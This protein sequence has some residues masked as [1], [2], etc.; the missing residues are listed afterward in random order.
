LARPDHPGQDDP[1][2]ASAKR[3]A[4]NAPAEAGVDV[5]EATLTTTVTGDAIAVA[6][7]GDSIDVATWTLISRITGVVKIAAIGAVLGPT[8]FGNTYQF[9]NSL[10]NLIYFGFLAGSLFSSLL[11]PALVRHVGAND[12]AASERIAG[13][14]LGTTLLTL[15]VAAPLAVVCGPM[16]LR[17]AS[18]G[19]AHGVG[20]AQE[21]V[22]RLLIVMFLPQLF[23]Y[24]V[25]GTATAAMNAHR[26]FALAAAAPALENVGI[27]VV[28]GVAAVSY[29]HGAR[30]EHVPVGLLVLLGLG[31]TGAVLL[32]AATQWWGA[33]R[34]GVTLVPR[35][36]WRD[37]EVTAVV[38]RALPSLAQAGL[39]A[40]QVGTLLALANRV[41]GGVTA[42][43]IALNCYFLAIALGATPVALSLLPRLAAMH[44]AQDVRSFSDTFA[45]GLSLGIFLA[46]PAAVGY[47]VLAWPL[48]HALSFGRMGSPAGVAMV[49]GALIALAA[50]VVAQTVF[51]I[52]TYASYA[53][54]DTTA[55]LRAMCGQAIACL[56]LASLA[57]LVHGAAVLTVLGMAFTISVAL[58]AMH[59]TRQ[60]RRGRA[61][62]SACLSRSVA[63]AALA[64]AVMA[65]PV[66][67]VA[68]AITQWVPG[69]LGAG[70]ALIC[71]TAVGAGVYLA[72]QARLGAPEL[73]WLTG[74]FAQLRSRGRSLGAE[75]HV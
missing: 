73:T 2:G 3:C 5:A 56:G 7:A 61:P 9:T 31:S 51:H 55:P 25:V 75:A 53:R 63:K 40:L 44:S 1:S 33:K 43:Q 23:L 62:E 46:I 18:I 26:R 57:L 45:R 19:G 12:S 60:L 16:I 67:F 74:G 34:A 54:L 20:A 64:A 48:A 52:A 15:V 68:R 6:A 11:V 35:A 24:A 28:L 50:A 17:L 38:R 65:A 22:G 4:M 41:P 8:F 71:A 30:L 37:P 49:A 10:P 29:P 58:A 32:H 69:S 72:I 39:V 47:V 42:F 59:L 36:G 14:V 21:R 27:L 13:G 70:I 66:W